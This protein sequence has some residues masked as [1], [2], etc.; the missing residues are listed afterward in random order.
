MVAVEFVLNFCSEV[1]K[2]NVGVM[3]SRDLKVITQRLVDQMRK[4]QH[5]P[6]PSI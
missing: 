3:R 6:I 1:S 4:W 5:V 2:G